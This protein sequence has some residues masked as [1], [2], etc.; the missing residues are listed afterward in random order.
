MVSVEPAAGIADALVTAGL[1][2]RLTAELVHVLEQLNPEE[3]DR[4]IAEFAAAVVARAVRRLPTEGRSVQAA[5]LAN[6]IVDLLTDES[7]LT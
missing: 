3:A 4:R 7:A 1:A 2:E 5:D 6:G